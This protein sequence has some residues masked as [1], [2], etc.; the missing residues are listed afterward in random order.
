MPEES[1]AAHPSPEQ[2]IPKSPKAPLL[3][4]IRTKAQR[5][6]LGIVG[7]LAAVSERL[8]VF[9]L[10]LVA[11][12][13]LSPEWARQIVKVEV[14]TLLVG[15]ATMIQLAEYAL[16]I[17]F[18]I[19]LALIW[20]S[21]II[22]WKTVFGSRTRRLLVKALNAVLALAATTTMI[23]WTNVKRG[24]EPWTALQKLF[25]QSAASALLPVNSL[26][27]S[28][29][30]VKGTV[31][32]G[33]TWRSPYTELDLILT[34]TSDD[35]Y[36]DLN[37]TIKP[38]HAVADI[39]QLSNLG[40][41]SFEDFGGFTSRPTIQ[42]L[43]KSYATPMPFIATD[44]GYRVHCDRIPAKSSLRIVMAL[45]D[46]KKAKPQ[47]PNQQIIGGMTESDIQAE[48]NAKSLIDGSSLT[49]WYGDPD[50]LFFYAERP[51]R[52]TVQI[53]GSYMAKNRKFH[54]KTATGN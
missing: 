9:N 36:D 54:V 41:V 43:S 32:A 13:R 6:W 37:V 11:K 27:T 51:Q 38:N 20:I 50:N 24:D 18:W 17:M 12:L 7:S 14:T 40:G 35:N 30:Y 1:A 33:I 21:K 45:V 15:G 23:A 34:N 22:N 2:P 46:L 19:M 52:V 5:V 4:R 10:W 28:M 42:D 48:F 8:Q 39:K 49:Y 44:A 16:A 47:A 53:S 29:E 26:V 3:S 25:G 31:I